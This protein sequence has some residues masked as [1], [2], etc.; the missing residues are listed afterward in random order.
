[1]TKELKNK[2]LKTDMMLT[3]DELDLIAG[4]RIDWY[5]RPDKAEYED[6]TVEEGYLIEGENKEKGTLVATRFVAKKDFD[7][8]KKMHREDNFISGYLK[9]QA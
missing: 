2:N 3:D 1:M 9:P 5:F 6:G 7:K 8:F 4:G